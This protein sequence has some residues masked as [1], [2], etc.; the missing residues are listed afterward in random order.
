MSKIGNFLI[1]DIFFMSFGRTARQ[2]AGAPE[3]FSELGCGLP[4]AYAFSSFWADP[5]A[6]KDHN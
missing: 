6:E 1:F 5:L 3:G 4:F 2:R